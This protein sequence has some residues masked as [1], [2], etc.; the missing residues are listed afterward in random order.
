MPVLR[1]VI[2]RYKFEVDKK[3]VDKFERTMSGMR[4]NTGKLA[5][6]FGISL[7]VAGVAAMGRLG[8]SIER[9][10]FNMQR[11]SG[12]STRQLNQQLKGV[13]GNLD[14]IRQGFGSK[15]TDKNFF[16]AGTQFFQAFGKGEEQ[17]Q[18]FRRTFEL[19]AKLSLLTGQNVNALFSNITQGIESG[20]FGFLADIPGFTKTRIQNLQDQLN[21]IAPGGEFTS[22]IG[23]AQR[24]NAFLKNTGR[25]SA[26]INRN[27]GQ[28]PDAVFE[29]DRAAASIKK[30]MDDLAQTLTRLLVPALEKM[31]I[32]LDKIVQTSDKAKRDGLISALEEP[33]RSAGKSA[34]LS[35]E[36][37]DASFLPARAAKRALSLIF[38]QNNTI[39]ASDPEGVAAEVAKQNQKLL[40]DASRQIVPTED[41]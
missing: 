33:I 27:L 16:T 24:L 15:V 18:A 21:A 22:G 4:R 9:A 20:N 37:M 5:R 11:F 25:S 23:R 17:M 35:K 34:G 13:R 38:N 28:I 30:T 12:L 32:L 6:M 14:A 10:R 26:V 29:A 2:T 3:G 41:R 40:Q 8:V 7:G 19:A 31:N 1:E 36:T 39:T